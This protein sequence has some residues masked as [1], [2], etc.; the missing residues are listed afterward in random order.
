MFGEPGSCAPSRRWQR[1]RVSALFADEAA[2]TAAARHSLLR[3]A[4]STLRIE[5]DRRRSPTRTGC[6]SP[7]RSSARA[8]IT[9]A[10]LDRADL[11]RRRRPRRGSVIRPRPRPAPSAPARIRRRACAC[12]GSPS[13]RSVAGTAG[14][15]CSTT[16]AARAS[17]R[18]ARRCSARAA[19]DAVDIDPAAVE[20]TRANAR[21]NGVALARRRCRMRRRGRTT[22]V[23]ANILAD[24]AEAARAAAVGACSTAGGRPGPGRH[25]RA[26]GRRTARRPIA[27]WLELDGRRP[28]RRLGADRRRRG[29]A[30][31][32]HGMI[33][34]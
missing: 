14:R 33:R 23:L 4:T 12:A 27:P 18:S 30:R 16:A 20:A 2:A 19:I 17:S 34:R 7:S 28:R 21:A 6:G 3:A 26:P 11:A 29:R 1:S 8:E 13:R 22:L 5:C 9:P 25:P 31:S 24:A 32:P 10:L 15:A